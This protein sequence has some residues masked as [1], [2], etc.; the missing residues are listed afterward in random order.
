MGKPEGSNVASQGQQGERGNRWRDR[1]STA[2]LLG[3]VGRS[4]TTAER[5]L[6]AATGEAGGNSQTRRRRGQ[7]W[8]SDRVGSLCPASGDAGLAEAVGPDVLRQQ[9]RFPAGP[10]NASGRG[11]SAAVYCCRL[12][13][14]GGSRLGEILRSSS[15]R[16]IDGTDRQTSR[17]QAAVEA[18]PG[19]LER[20]GDGERV[21]QSQRGRD[22]ARRPSFAPAQQSRARR[23][24]PGTGGAGDIALFAMR[25]IATSTFAPNER[26]NG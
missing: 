17:R 25:M 6:Y 23:T 8:H 2:G 26:V 18:H 7:A 15:S 1:R 24:R 21:G 9:L 12:W 13:L 20:R 14:G 5:D 19:V 4:G 3:T 11:A 22:P 10:V 16:Q